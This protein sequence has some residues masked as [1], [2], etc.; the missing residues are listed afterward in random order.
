MN[1]KKSVVLIFRS[2]GDVDSKVHFNFGRI[3]LEVKEKFVYLGAKFSA[4]RG[5]SRH[6]EDLI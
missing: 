5:M 4:V 2:K 6:V 1:A 3:M